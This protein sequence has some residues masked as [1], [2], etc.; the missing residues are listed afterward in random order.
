VKDAFFALNSA[1]ITPDTLA[2]IIRAAQYLVQ[3]PKI[4]VLISGWTDPRGT[5]DYNIALGIRR[6]NAVRNALIDAGVPPTQLEVISNGKS[7]QVCAS[8]DQKCWQMNRRVSYNMK[9]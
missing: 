9:P 6:A 1:K 4:Q 5:A 7:S 8:K 2:T 3:H